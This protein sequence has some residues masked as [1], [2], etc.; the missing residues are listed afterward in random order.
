MIEILKERFRSNIDR[1]R[2]LVAI[3]DRV[4]GG[5]QGRTGVAE[6]DLLRAAVVFL[7]ASLEDLLREIATWRLPHAGQ[8]VLS[9]IPFAG[10]DGRKTTL[11]LG[12]LARHRGK[13][14]DELIAES[15]VT[16]LDR[17]SYNG[18]DDIAKLFVQIDFPSEATKNLMVCHAAGL[19]ALMSRRHQIVHRLDWRKI[20]GRRRHGVLPIGKKSIEVWA[21]SVLKFSDEIFKE[22]E[23]LPFASKEIP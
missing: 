1:A 22:L 12:D 9:R 3:Y 10:G 2:N 6:S 7:H 23:K 17:S 5:V 13:G 21:D 11:T 16:H 19:E 18:I 15:I 14:V 20:S 4:A 8:E